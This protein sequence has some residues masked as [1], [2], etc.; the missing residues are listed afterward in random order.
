[1]LYS[2]D[3][4]KLEIEIAEAEVR[5]RNARERHEALERMIGRMRSRLRRLKKLC[6]FGEQ[7][8]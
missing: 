5:C 2:R 8:D 1:M 6:P 3:I 4:R 7:G